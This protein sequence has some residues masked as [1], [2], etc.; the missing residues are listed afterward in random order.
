MKPSKAEEDAF[1]IY[2]RL[3]GNEKLQ[4]GQMRTIEF[5]GIKYT[6]SEWLRYFVNEIYPDIPR[7]NK[8]VQKLNS[9]EV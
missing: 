9:R 2:D 7:Y 6:Q 3:V 1:Y 8:L 4:V 5:E